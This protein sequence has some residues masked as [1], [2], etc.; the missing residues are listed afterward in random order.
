MQR[1][2][3]FL[4]GVLLLSWSSRAISQSV[5]LSEGFESV[6]FQ[7]TSSGSAQWTQFNVLAAPGNFSTWASITAPGDSAVLTS[8]SFSTTG[9]SHI[10][11]RFNHICKADFFDG[12]YIEVSSDNGTTWHRLTGAHYRGLGLFAN[13]TNKFN[14]FSYLDW[15]PMQPTV[16]PAATWW[17]HEVFD[18]SAIVTNASQA[19]IRFILKDIDNNGSAGNYGWLLDDIK[20][21]GGSADLIPPQI[22]LSL[23]SPVDS[24]PGTGPFNVQATIIDSNGVAAAWLVYTIGTYNDSVPMIFLGN[25]LWSADIP[26]AAYQ[27]N[28]CYSIV[29]RDSAVYQNK[30]IFP[31]AGCIGFHNYKS[32]VPVLVGTATTNSHYAPV[33]NETA[34]SMNRYSHHASLFTPAD[35]NGIQGVIQRI[36]WDKANATGYSGSNAQLRIYLKHTT[37]TGVPLTASALAA[38][39]TSA[40]LVFED[41]TL[42]LTMNTG[43]QEFSF[44]KGTFQYNGTSN[45]LV[46][47]EWYRNGNL[48]GDY[49]NWHYTAA[50]QKGI[51]FSG[52]TPN[53]STAG[54]SGHRPNTRFTINST[55]YQH[56]ARISGIIAPT[57]TFT[58]AQPVAVTVRIKNEGLATLQKTTIHWSVNGILQT[59]YLWTGTLGSDLVSADIVLGSYFFPN[60]NSSLAVW[61]SLPN[62]STDQN[63]YN[64]TLSSQVF[65]CQAILNGTYTLGSPSADFA[66]FTDLFNALYSCGMSGASVIQVL[67]GTY[68]G[69]FIIQDSIP[70]LSA[71]NTLKITTFD[72][73]PGSVTLINTSQNTAQNFVLNLNGVKH[74]TIDRLRIA[75]T[76]TSAGQCITLTNRASNNTISNCSLEMAYG[77][78]FGVS[79]I[80][81]NGGCNYNTLIGN[82]IT[83]GYRSIVATGTSGD[84][85]VGLT[86]HGNTLTDGSR[87][88]TDISYNDSLVITGNTVYC[89]FQAPSSSRYGV[90]I[91]QSLRSNITGNKIHMLLAGF[92]YAIW[93]Q[94]NNDA[95]ASRSLI[96][97]NFIVVTGTSTTYGSHAILYSGSSNTR[98]FH[99][100]MM[101]STGNST[102][103]TINFEGNISGVMMMNNVMA[104]LAGGFAMNGNAAAV[105]AFLQ[106]NYNNFFTTGATLA[107]WNGTLLVPVSGGIAALTTVTS[108]D[109]NSMITNPLFYS[110]T[111]LHSFSPLMNNA[112]IPLP[113]V[114][115]DID[116]EP[117]S[118]TTPDIGADEYAVSAIDAGIMAVTAPSG[119]LSQG[120]QHPV[121]VVVRNFGSA[122]LA[123]IPIAYQLNGGTPV[124]GIWTGSLN[125][126]QT[127]T[128]TLPSVTIP[129]MNF[130]LTAFTNLTGD[131]LL[132]N[133]TATVNLFGNPL[134]DLKQ[135]QLVSPVGGCNP[136]SDSVKVVIKNI[137][138]Q[139]TSGSFSLSYQREGLAVVSE[140]VTTIIPANG[141]LTHTFATPVS[142]LTTQD[143]AFGLSVWVNATGDPNQTN[144]TLYALISV[145]GPLPDPVV[146]DTTISYGQSVALTAISNYPTEWYSLP[147]GGTKLVTSSTFITPSLFDTTVYYVEANTNI[148]AGEFFVGQGTTASGQYEWPNPFGKAF[149]GAKHQI[150]VLA[151]ELLSQGYSAGD[152]TSVSFFSSMAIGQVTNVDVLIGTT[153]N[154]SATT[155][156]IGSTLNPVFSGT[157]NILAG[158]FTIPFPTP[159][160]WDG[161]SNLVI[162]TMTGSGATLFNPPIVYGVTSTAMVT[163]TTGF[164]APSAT[165][166]TVSFNRPNLRFNTLGTP[167]CNS[168]RVPVTVVVPPLQ[169]DVL[170]GRI[171]APVSGCGLGQTPVTIAIV[172]HGFDTI[173]GGIQAR[174]RI[175]S[176]TFTSPENINSTILPYDTLHYTFSTQASLPSG[177]SSQKHVITAVATM[178]GDMYTPN[179]TLVSDSIT[180]FYTP[181]PFTA[182]PTTIPYGTV[183][184]LAPNASDTLYWYS[185]ST[186]QQHF[187]LGTPFITQPLYDTTTWW[188]ESRFTT[189]Q[190][191]Y[192]LGTGSNYNNSS[193][194][195]SPYGSTQFGAKH[196]FLIRASELLA[197]GM[198]KGEILSIGFNVAGTGT[199]QLQDYAIAIGHTSQSTM[200]TFETNLTPYFYS[201]SYQVTNGISNHQ[202]LT[203][204]LWDGTSNLVIETCFKNSS[205]GTLSQVYNSSTSFSSTLIGIGGA[206]FGCSTA[207]SA[208]SYTVRPN[209]YLQVV[210]TGDCSSARVPVQVNVSGIPAVDAA[211]TQIL[212]PVGQISGNTPVSV[213]I[214][215][216]NWGTSPLT[217]ATIYYQANN[218]TPASFLWTGNL[219]RLATTTVNPGS[220]VFAGGI[221]NLKVWVA[222]PGDQTHQND[223]ANTQLHVCMQGT[224]AIGQGKRYQTINAAVTEL[225]TVGVCGHTIFEIDPG[226]YGERVQIPSVPGVS[227]NAT[228]TFTSATADSTSVNITEL[229]TA[230]NPWVISLANASWIT[231]SKITITANGSA[232]GYAVSIDGSS[233]NI[234]IRQC[235]LNGASSTVSGN[236]AAIFSTSQSIRNITIFN[237]RIIS[238]YSGIHLAG[239]SSSYQK[240]LK[241]S[242]NHL[243]D[244]S[245]YGIYAYYQDSLEI[246]H[247]RII[248]GNS[249]QYYYGIRSHYLSGSIAVHGNRMTIYPIT[250]GYGI[251]MNFANGTSTAYGLVYNNMIS[252]LTGTGAHQAMTSA[253][254]QFI[255]YAYNSIAIFGTSST[256]RGM[257]VSSGGNIHILNNSFAIHGTGHAF[258]T[259]I[260]GTITVMDHNNYYTDPLSSTF[261]H[262]GGAISSLAAFK[263]F[264][265]SK[266]LNSISAEPLYKSSTDLHTDNIL[267]NGKATPVAGITDD[268]DGDPRH[269]TTPDI[270]AD[271]F[272]PPPYDLALMKII[273]PMGSSC[274]FNGTDSIAIRL[275]NSGENTWDFGQHPATIRIFIS[276]QINDT[277]M[278]ILGTGTLQSGHSTD[279]TVHPAYNL[280]IP[281]YYSMIAQ[282]TAGIDTVADNNVLLLFEFISLPTLSA[283]PYTEG[284]ES[285]YNLT[286]TEY[287]GS[288]VSITVDANAAMAGSK[289]LHFEGGGYSGSWNNPT[290]V[291][292]AF[293]NQAKV[294]QVT[295]CQVVPVAGLKLKFDM[296][297]TYT[298]AG[299]PNTSWVRVML[300]NATGS[301]YL[302]NQN[303]DSVFRA[304]TPNSDPFYTHVF[305][306]Q[307]F[308]SQPYSISIDG[309]CRLRNGEGLYSGDNVYIDNFTLWSPTPH[310]ATVHQF[311]WPAKPYNKAGNLQYI[312]VLISNLG[313][314]SITSLPAS[315]KA[316]S[317]PVVNE[318]FQVSIPPF[319]TDTITFTVPFLTQPGVQMVCVYTALTGDGNLLN[320]SLCM[321]F[322]GLNTFN[323]PFKDD[324]EG[325]DYWIAEGINQQWESGAPGGAIITGAA[326]GSSVWMTLL[327]QQYKPTSIEYLYSPYFT[328]PAGV[329][330]TA[331]LSFQ[332]WMAV[333]PDRAYGIIQYSTN[334]GQSWNNIGY[335]GSGD[336]TNWYNAIVTGLHCWSLTHPGWSTSSHILYPSIFNT[337][338]PFQFRF[339]FLTANYQ[340]LS[341]G[342]AIDDFAITIPPPALD[343]AMMALTSPMITTH[344][345]DT[346]TVSV[347]VFNHGTDTIYA[348]TLGYRINA[349]PPIT[350]TWSG[351]LASGDTLAFT[352]TTPFTAPV[353]DYDV[354]AFAKAAGDLYTYNDTV[355]KYLT[356]A[357]G[358]IDA[359]IS[360]VIS[361]AGQVTTN[362]LTQVTVSLHNFGLDTLM[363]IPVSYNVGSLFI[364]TDTFNGVLLPGQ[365]LPFTFA[366]GY[367]SPAGQYNVCA[368]TLLTGDVNPL[369]NESCAPILA[370]SINENQKSTF[371]VGQN[372]PNPA[373][374]VTAI[375]VKIVEAGIIHISI[376][377]MTG[378]LLEQISHTLLPGEHSIPLQTRHL[379]EGV[380]LYSVKQNNIV[381]TRR[382]T[383]LR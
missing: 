102:A 218:Q 285:G 4:I 81:M 379:A 311:I 65:G 172:N 3:Y 273:Q 106:S 111:D 136:G 222:V 279:F 332:Q 170:V 368:R 274:G 209:I 230:A 227:A 134:I 369:N 250:Y 367:N 204:F 241:I 291:A 288:D 23:S 350:E 80:V 221:E 354:C 96:A 178:L 259:T 260:P 130:T 151:T 58:S 308:N 293:L 45:L 62:D 224:Y 176:G 85:V 251:D 100:S 290:T 75:T 31:A 201:A 281:G 356:A 18:L 90:S 306:L 252:I 275:R 189:P 219:P 177:A 72:P 164:G 313:T 318:V 327:N 366:T 232:N 150:L 359:G 87:Y 127:D 152:I 142:L 199:S 329:T 344:A 320:D 229:T 286:F 280:S 146:Q 56:D 140:N 21:E 278:A 53:P 144:D 57:G 266:N 129:P 188:V 180:S 310:D 104:N 309:V 245:M 68:N 153:P 323:V 163:F 73:T 364:A 345:G 161:S 228:I 88:A 89:S 381:I 190:T 113:D 25:N 40:V 28:L 74:I 295:T 287:Q 289:G 246:N 110:N 211:V 171:S 83:N 264:D 54:G 319:G 1:I 198:K 135:E 112:G 133:D 167:G 282:L 300:H 339:T 301:H 33:F 66:T 52:S 376:Y 325:T 276:G 78:N 70:G 49:V 2:S 29:A 82:R 302:H 84:Q 69:P 76:G 41:T 34:T 365:T 145:Q 269:T 32:P 284:F 213:S 59:P 249:S 149:G 175:S 265:P 330:D 51:T 5:L 373:N 166:G 64:D 261:I 86:L 131:T 214:E 195:P 337:G 317:A 154:N 101:L 200:G 223:T 314:Q 19:R 109:T 374:V 244:F 42:N 206:T 63:P 14:A 342:W 60:G 91:N 98:I 157:V 237:N 296:K 335:I 48:S 349:S 47:V 181:T 139:A 355:C 242:H 93:Y 141:T 324:F 361:P 97:N 43:W 103:S 362:A 272:S 9:S 305:D 92:G 372:I 16:L 202:G 119:N 378:H 13:F 238:G 126:G 283:F 377:S 117:R 363:M 353:Y 343:V 333:V 105:G 297:Q 271:E 334:L 239:I 165:S 128:L 371:F 360:A 107:R 255:K 156:F 184:T 15:Q 115:T 220:V 95:A 8:N 210:S 17:K 382:M 138:T 331:I 108:Q 262:W 123:N 197:A 233:N 277:L 174:Y 116:G 340:I 173:F 267:F 304:I 341:D 182:A 67:P 50:P 216:K 258:Y 254:N 321:Y 26:S 338:M 316:G 162:Q 118:A 294:V 370:T 192:Q 55:N 77:E 226:N 205:N 215:L 35:I 169:K 307:N 358:W 243:S 351:S 61:T 27:S 348:M 236:A 312:S 120:A 328:I 179:D 193:T 11:L 22:I 143:T 36:A 257:Q 159:F 24:V 132:F 194:F 268:I 248:S 137:G 336:G 79:G 122:N 298:S 7:L 292:N 185:S 158:W 380:Y 168:N 12:G 155:T 71:T 6:P 46:L 38:E 203:P 352:F 44:N 253:N 183:A 326:S 99:N 303:G 39:L 207:P 208:G 231:L 235:V 383:I 357:P 124:T 121:K 30:A 187:H 10:V 125:T 315:Y 240:Q 114:T 225:I 20:I 147:I 247:N 217:T 256:G 160:V 37:A 375:P 94:N 191:T 347:Q 270:G 263:A 196:Q 322:K 299:N 234:Q 148:P 212:S 186:A 346:T